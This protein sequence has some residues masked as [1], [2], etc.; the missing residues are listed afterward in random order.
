MDANICYC[1]VWTPSEYKEVEDKENEKTF[2][3]R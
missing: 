2:E 3:E 1:T